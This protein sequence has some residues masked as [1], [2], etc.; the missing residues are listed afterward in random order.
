M[1]KNAQDQILKCRD[2]HAPVLF[3]EDPSVAGAPQPFKLKAGL[4]C[5][6]VKPDEPFGPD[7]LRARIEPWLTALFQSEHLAL[8]V[9]S[10]LTH[11]L[12][13]MATGGAL[14]GMSTSDL[15]IFDAEIAA[16]AKR[17]AAAAGREEG[18]IEDQIRVASE[19]LRGLQI[20]AATKELSAKEHEHVTKL[21]E[22]I[23]RVLGE[24]ASSILKGEAGSA[25]AP[26]EKREE[27]FNYLVSFLMCF[28]SRSGTRDR[29]QLFTTGTSKRERMQRAYTSL[30]AS[31]AH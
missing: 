13:S 19:L 1:T 31:W 15:G 12:H 9:G 11:A 6:W 20:A 4:T 17:S 5:P 24:F 3:C 8:L 27:A 14:P 18:N 7:K 23:E 28:A 16:E 26:A 30:T 25:S 29:L 21:K 22:G 10:G 2:D